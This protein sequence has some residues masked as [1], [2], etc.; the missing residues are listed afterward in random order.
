VIAEVEVNPRTG[1]IWVRRFFV[2]AD[3]GIIINPFTLDRTIEGNL[4][5]TTSRTLYEEVK[6]DRKMV[7]SVDWVTYPILNSMDAPEEIRIKKIDRPELGKPMGAGEPT[8]RI[9]PAAIANAFYD[10]T[11]IRMRKIPFTPA[12]VKAALDAVG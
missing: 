9:T 1:R 11:G 8:T 6:F 12:R 10:A 4:V 5:Q 3:H 2:G 7:N